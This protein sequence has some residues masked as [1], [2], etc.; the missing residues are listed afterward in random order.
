MT[1]VYFQLNDLIVFEKELS[2]SDALQGGLVS[3]VIWPERFQEQ[4]RA[5]ANDIAAQ[6]LEVSS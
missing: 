4:V 1:F 2:A 6:P 3:R 5:I